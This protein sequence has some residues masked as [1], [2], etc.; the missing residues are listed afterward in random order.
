MSA[1]LQTV[2]RT[3]GRLEV[4][5]AATPPDHWSNGLPFEADGSLACDAANPNHYHQGLPYSVNNRICYAGGAT[6]AP[7]YFGSGAAPFQGAN[8]RISFTLGGA[9][10]HY[11][12]GIAYLPNGRL[13]AT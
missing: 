10:D 1:L 12:S 13:A 6:P 5:V 11:S 4:T 8:A 2:P 3:E 9:T 7:A